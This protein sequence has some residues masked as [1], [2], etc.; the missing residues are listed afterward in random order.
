MSKAGESVLAL[1]G[2]LDTVTA[3]QLQETLIPQFDSA[4]RI[5]LDFAELAYISSAGLR[6]LLLAEKTAQA[7]NV[8][9][10]LTKVCPEIMKIFAMTGFAEILTIQ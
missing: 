2:R 6:V 10:R 8:P 5:T 9:M 1:S 3:P 7:K 4:E